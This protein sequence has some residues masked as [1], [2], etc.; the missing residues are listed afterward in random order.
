MVAIA[1]DKIAPLL[2][3]VAGT[4]LGD[5]ERAF[6]REHQPMGFLL[7]ARNI[8]TPEQVKALCEDICEVSAFSPPMIAVDQEGGRVQRLHFN[9]RLPAARIFGDWYGHNAAAALEA[10]RLDALLLASE[11]R[12]VGA[13]WLLGP[14]LD[15]AHDVTHAIIGDRSFSGD[16]DTIVALGQAFMDGVTS[17]GCWHCIKHA[18]GHGLAAADSHFSLPQVDESLVEM[19]GDVLPFRKLAARAD[20][21]M[22]AHI[23]YMAL[24]EDNPATF[25]PSI[26]NMM[27]N[28]WGF[29]GLILAD[30][31]GMQALDGSYESRIER[32]LAAGCDVAITSLSLLREGMAGTVFD[33]AH[34]NDLQSAELPELNL[35]ARA[36]LERLTL[37]LAPA[38]EIVAQARA[39]LRELW[40]DG[41]ARMG[42]KLDL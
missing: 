33:E 10:V 25:S 41:P 18:P 9:G 39:R 16:A 3:G 26:L 34:F 27:R 15:R 36:F 24:D 37:P 2:M 40:A 28:E 11:L 32:S 20:F 38:D 19:E 23:R 30:D 21:M 42:Y 6:I 7:F 5:A 17:G 13:N 35:F 12:A 1:A 22:T 31:V 29:G 4:V 14:V 8:E